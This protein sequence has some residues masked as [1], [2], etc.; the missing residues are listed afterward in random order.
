[1]IAVD[2][3]LLFKTRLAEA[4]VDVPG[5]GTVRVRGLSRAEVMAIR[6]ATDNDPAT[7][8]GQRVLVLERKMISLAMVDPKLTEAEVKLWQ[9]AAPAGELQPVADRIQELSGLAEGAT[10]SGVQ[11]DGIG[12]GSGDGV[13]RGG[14]AGSDGGRAE[15]ES[16]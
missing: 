3:E 11:S 5:V 16:E 10:K 9:D 14:E 2:K 8:D 6:K 12:P 1:M 15:G 7:L 4:D 13:L